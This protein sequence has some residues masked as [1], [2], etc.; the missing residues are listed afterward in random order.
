M[1][2]NSSTG[3]RLLWTRLRGLRGELTLGALATVVQQGAML[4]LPWCVQRAIDHGITARS[5]HGTVTW[6]VPTVLWSRWRSCWA[7]PAAC[8]GRAGPRPALPTGCAPR[9]S[10]GWPPSTGPP[11]PATAT[12]T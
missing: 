5:V 9:S 12:V 10:S 2:V 4:A 6:V 8:G 11:S 7:A 1:R 3:S